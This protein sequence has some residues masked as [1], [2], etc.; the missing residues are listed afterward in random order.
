MKVP[1]FH[2]TLKDKHRP[3]NKDLHKFLTLGTIWVDWKGHI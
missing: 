2:L 3:K 1:H